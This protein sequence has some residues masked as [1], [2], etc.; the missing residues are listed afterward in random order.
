MSV[1]LQDGRNGLPRLALSHPS[2]STAEVY[3]HGAHLTSWVPAG[4]VEALFLSRAAEFASG[5]P[6]RGGVPIV[7]PQFAE[8]GPLPKHGFA[9]VQPWRWVDPREGATSA[10][11]ELVDSEETRASWPHAFRAR[12]TVELGERSLVQ[13]L[14]VE[15]TGDADLSFTVALHTYFAVG[16]L[17]RVSVDGVAGVEYEE[18]SA[19]GAPETTEAGIRITGELD[20][21]YLDAP[22]DLRVH[23]GANA[24]ALALRL[25]GFG[26]VVVWNPG[27]EGAS[28]LPDME[29]DEHRR[30]ICV[31][32][33]RIGK[34]V[35][36]G[37]GKRW[38]GA[39]RVEAADT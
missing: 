18:R 30:M 13:R 32:A 8:R 36:L 25:D 12:M 26:D 3:L 31:E 19:R 28:A 16:E 35:T 7:F 11:L 1:A 14:S 33:A 23:D 29:G 9:R 2:G 4:G 34:P 27:E 39:E 24:R 38:E 5:R 10:T 15:N 21:V 37:P 17:T 22:S 6:I 20:R